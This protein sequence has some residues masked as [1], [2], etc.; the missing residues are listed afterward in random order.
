MGFTCSLSY[1]DAYTF[2]VLIP[3]I[4]VQARSMQLAVL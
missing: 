1:D 3:S 2:L 4:T